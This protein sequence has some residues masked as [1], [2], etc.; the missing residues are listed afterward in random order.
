MACWA[1]CPGVRTRSVEKG[2]VLYQ[3]RPN[4]NDKCYH[5]FAMNNSTQ[6]CA[7]G[8]SGFS[9]AAT[10]IRKTHPIEGSGTELEEVNGERETR[11]ASCGRVRTDRFF[12]VPFF[13]V[14]YSY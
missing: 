2:R 8:G 3:N 5:H 4:S 10:P 14:D 12:E 13:A 9:V 6:N 1:F 11:P 7:P